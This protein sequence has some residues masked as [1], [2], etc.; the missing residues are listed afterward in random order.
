MPKERPKTVPQ[1]PTWGAAEHLLSHPKSAEY[2]D[3]ALPK[4]VDKVNRDRVH[5]RVRAAF[6]GYQRTSAG[7]R[8]RRPLSS[9]TEQR[10]QLKKIS[11]YA[12]KLCE[13]LESLTPTTT[14]Y[15]SPKKDNPFAHQ[16]C[17]RTIALDPQK[18]ENPFSFKPLAE[19]AESA[20]ERMKELNRTAPKDKAFHDLLSQLFVAWRIGAPGK[21]G[22]TRHGAEANRTDGEGY[23]GPLLDFVRQ[24]LKIEG[25]KHEG[26]GLG[27]RLYNLHE[28][29]QT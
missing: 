21:T 29:R 10:K 9:L 16:Y 23:R 20:R 6:N 26:R 19:R 2:I 25:I 17:D 22:I 11:A 28:P 14:V 15:L 4:D 13:C 18:S 3:T 8:A 12:T 7:K 5:F 27:K 24:L 1:R